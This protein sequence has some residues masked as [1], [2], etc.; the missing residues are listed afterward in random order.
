M[1]KIR[2]ICVYAGPGSGKSTLAAGLFSK[3]KIA[4]YDIEH[5]GEYVKTWAYQGYQ[6]QSY[7]QLYIFAKQVH[8]EDAALRH[9][10]RIVTDCPLLM[11]CTYAQFYGFPVHKQLTDI[12]C[13]FDEEFPAL[14]LLIE[15]TVPYNGKG[16][17]QSED[18]AH[19]FDEI[20]RENMKLCANG[21]E[22]V[23]VDDFLG[24]VDL[25]QRRIEVADA[26]QM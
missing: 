19:E 5:V 25:V 13:A 4:G 17:Y 24:I 20:L 2:R 22:T 21:Y 3:F 26:L 6:P 15:R 1:S 23:R 9:V 10:D 7:D 14:N 8:M 12:A 18:Q 16:R 11:C